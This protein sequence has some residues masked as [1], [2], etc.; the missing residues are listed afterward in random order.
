MNLAWSQPL[1]SLIAFEE[2][3]R[4]SKKEDQKS[5]ERK[6]EIEKE[7]REGEKKQGEK[8]DKREKEGKGNSTV[9]AIKIQDI[10]RLPAF[11]VSDLVDINKVYFGF[12]L[13]LQFLLFIFRSILVL[14]FRFSISYFKSYSLFD[15]VVKKTFAFLV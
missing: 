9:H 12:A 7:E 13:L 15:L 3:Y 4:K 14:D 2:K 1:S 11:K 6:G 10:L 8:E 5:E